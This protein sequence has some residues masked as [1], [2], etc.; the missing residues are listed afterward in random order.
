V[1][2]ILITSKPAA[3]TLREYSAKF[4]KTD[5]GALQVTEQE[6]ADASAAWVTSSSR[7]WPWR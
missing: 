3:M 5:V 1:A 4:D 6:I 7:R 2:E